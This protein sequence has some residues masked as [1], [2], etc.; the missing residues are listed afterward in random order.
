MLRKI[1]FA[2][3]IAPPALFIAVLLGLVTFG[4][5]SLLALATNGTSHFAILL[6]A[7][8]FSGILVTLLYLQHREYEAERLRTVDE[9]LRVI[10]DM[11]QEVRS[12]LR[13]MAFYGS[14]TKNDH[15]LKVFEDCFNRMDTIMR[16][17]LSRSSSVS[18]SDMP[19]PDV[20]IQSRPFRLWPQLRRRTASVDN[21]T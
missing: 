11:N 14:Q 10:R 18:E 13:I 2:N 1:G 7:N 6:T 3:K 8:S 9:N 15:A 20:T 19:V 17:V 5:V 16:E 21:I 12:V 4:T